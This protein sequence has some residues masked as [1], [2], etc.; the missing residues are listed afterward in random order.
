VK[1]VEVKQ[2][3]EGAQTF[4][5][6]V[7]KELDQIVFTISASARSPYAPDGN[8]FW[9]RARQVGTETWSQTRWAEME[10]QEGGLFVSKEIMPSSLWL[11]PETTY[12]IEVA[13]ETIEPYDFS[14]NVQM[15]AKERAVETGVV[16]KKGS[17]LDNP[18]VWFFWMLLLFVMVLVWLA[19]KR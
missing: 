2:S 3:E 6:T 11:T 4:I 9:L 14:L 17:T 5:V 16:E 15:K 10:D 13:P 1:G 19:G 7:P 8:I 12:E 18:M